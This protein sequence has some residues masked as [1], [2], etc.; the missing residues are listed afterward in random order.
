MIQALY[1]CVSYGFYS[2]ALTPKLLFFHYK[3]LTTF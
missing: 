3:A 2:E 1:D